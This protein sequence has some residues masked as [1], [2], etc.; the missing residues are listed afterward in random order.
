M[1]QK[2]FVIEDVFKITGRGI[3]VTGELESDSPTFKVGSEVVLVKPDGKEFLT[4]VTGIEHVKPINYENFN[5]KRVGVMLKNIVDKEDI[6][7]GSE[8][9]F[10]T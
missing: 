2:L 3:V 10:D 7:I 5:W 4:E 1:R 8:G 6:P 9:F